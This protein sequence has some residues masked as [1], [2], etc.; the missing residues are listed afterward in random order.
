MFS[1]CFYLYITMVFC[2]LSCMNQPC[3]QGP[4]AALAQHRL[5][6]TGTDRNI[7]WRSGEPAQT[8]SEHG[9]SVVFHFVICGC[10][11][12]FMVLAYSLENRGGVF[13]LCYDF[14]PFDFSLSLSLQYHITCSTSDMTHELNRF[15]LCTYFLN[16]NF[17]GYL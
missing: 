16:R 15:L 8:F 11:L 13:L 17:G 1:Y 9:T 3:P 5:W 14:A 6:S 7:A 4:N 2:Y 10:I 12:D